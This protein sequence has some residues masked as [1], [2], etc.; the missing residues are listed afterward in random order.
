MDEHTNEPQE[1]HDGYEPMTAAEQADWDLYRLSLT[2]K[3]LRRLLSQ[4]AARGVLDKA[5]SREAQGQLRTFLAKA[6]ADL[7]TWQRNIILGAAT[8]KTFKRVAEDN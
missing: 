5:L 6:Q 1:F 7:A 4:L 8:V 2:A 3:T